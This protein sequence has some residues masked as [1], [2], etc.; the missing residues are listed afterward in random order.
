MAHIRPAPRVK[1]ICGIIAAQKAGID[2]AVD[3]LT[4]R[5]GQVDVASETFAFDFTDYYR[6]QMG[7][8]LLRKFV[9][10]A[11]LVP[12]DALA[13]AKRWTNQQEAELAVELSWP[14]G[15]PRP[16]NLDPGYVDEAKLVLASMKDFSHRVCLDGGVFAEVTCQFRRGRWHPLPWTFPDY[17]SGRY[18]AFLTAARDALRRQ[19]RTEAGR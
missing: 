15:P 6:E 2:R 16:V 3:V 17:A 13:A 11:S 10:F 9:A 12:A 1:L 14:S 5:F 19:K 18:D 4:G 7:P 8:D